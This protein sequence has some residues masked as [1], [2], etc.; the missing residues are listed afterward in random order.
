MFGFD[1]LELTDGTTTI[2]L[3]QPPR[4]LIP[5]SMPDL[6]VATLRPGTLG[7]NGPYADVD[8]TIPINITGAC[9]ADVY[10][11]LGATWALL[12]QA[13]RFW[14]GEAVSAVVIK[15]RA[16]GSA[17]TDPVQALVLRRND[18]DT[19]ITLPPVYEVTVGNYIMQDVQ[20][21]FTRRGEWQNA[22]ASTASSS[23]T[24]VGN[25]FSITLPNHTTFSPVRLDMTLPP[26]IAANVTY[27]PPIIITTNDSAKI[28]IV[29]AESFG[30]S[31]VWTVVTP[32]A[33]QL[34]RGSD[35]LS[36]AV[37]TTE[38]FS[39]TIATPSLLQQ[40]GLFGMWAVMN[41]PLSAVVYQ[42]RFQIFI[43]GGGFL[44]PFAAVQSQF[45]GVPQPFFLGTF[46]LPDDLGAQTYRFAVT[47]STAVTLPI[48]YFV[49]VK[50]DQWT[51]NIAVVTS[52]PFP[53]ATWPNTTAIKFFVDPVLRSKLVPRVGRSS[54]VNTLIANANYQGNAVF[55]H[56]GATLAGIMLW[57]MGTA[58][59]FTQYRLAD[60]AGALYTSV[61]T[62][63]RESA[64]LTLP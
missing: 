14:K 3:L 32:A 33:N 47:A 29:E 31:G 25:V 9:P 53:V 8:C 39:G 34:A 4:L 37:V 27:P 46:A 45:S 50:L 13:Q 56:S 62:A 63:T 17:I 12:D 55:M 44:T 26:A 36:G 2:S 52:L 23:A 61:I 58:A 24:A 49:F 38:S 57:T 20:L 35:V 64:Y 41:S 6:G 28:A 54:S 30:A 16:T 19:P 59:P 48:D 7:G 43:P 18:A 1:I 11:A 42:F 51:N 60:G 22:T 10:T 40:G 5:E 15:A 21:R